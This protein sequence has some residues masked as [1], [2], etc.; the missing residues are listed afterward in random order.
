M[1]EQKHDPRLRLRLDVF[2]R[3]LDVVEEVKPPKAEVSVK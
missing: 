3:A 1:S 2:V